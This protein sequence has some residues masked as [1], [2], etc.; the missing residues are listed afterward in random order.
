M[1]AEGHAPTTTEYIQ[2]HLT[3]WTYGKLPEGTYCDGARVQDSASWVVAHCREE[4]SAMG[5]NAIHLDSMAWSIGLGFIFIL[6]F[7]YA[8]KKAHTGVPTGWL[9]FVE[10]AVEF[11]DKVVKDGFQ[12]RNA[13]IAPMA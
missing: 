12:H 5:F 8:A 4:M 10:M 1:A 2:H 9:N 3:N 11:I 7:R 13:L 6:L